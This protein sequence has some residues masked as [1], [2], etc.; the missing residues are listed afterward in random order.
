MSLREHAREMRREPTKAEQRLWH[1]LRA[2]RFRGLKF[3]RQ[4]PLGNYIAD[5]VCFDC[6]LI[7]EVDGSQHLG[8][9]TYDAA[10]D[11]FFEQEGFTIMRFWNDEVLNQTVAVLEQI[12]KHAQA[13]AGPSPRLGRGWPEGSGEGN[14]SDDKA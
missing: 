7:V 4:Y 9:H 14:F 8:A 13:S 1:Y 11:A 5:F 2:H 12:H 6:M 10:R 3:K